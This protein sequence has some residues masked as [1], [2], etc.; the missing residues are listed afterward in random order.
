MKSARPDIAL[1]AYPRRWRDR[2][3]DELAALLEDSYGTNGL[4]RMETAALV[5]RGLGERVRYCR[6]TRWGDDP[7]EVVRASV[8][9]SVAGWV[10]VVI[11][12][13]I[14]SKATEHWQ[15]Y[16][17]GAT[18]NVANAGYAIVE[19]AGIVSGLVVAALVC[20]ALPEA[21][22]AVLGRKAPRSA[23]ATLLAGA[24]AAV[25][26]GAVGALTP[27]AHRLTEQQRNGGYAF[28]SAMWL[29]VAVLVVLTL[30]ACLRAATT[31]ARERCWSD[32]TLRAVSWA[33]V[34]LSMTLVV[35]VAGIGV[36][37]AAIASGAHGY[38]HA[39]VFGSESSPAPP[40]LILMGLLAL[41]GLAMAALA[42]VGIVI[43]HRRFA[44]PVSSSKDR[45]A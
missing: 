26:A 31:W 40:V 12:G 7:Q 10:V 24:I 25:T 20:V 3:G 8:M 35:T 5:I 44:I 32:R 21:V 34:A 17:Y 28:Y 19:V 33:S 18:K 4:T 22:R 15:G 1:R 43:A 13:L 11:A 39:G 38:F 41:V 27:W 42:P 23:Q 6:P 2:Y 9:V 30:L 16:A 14:F 45:E 36:W 37:W 29:V